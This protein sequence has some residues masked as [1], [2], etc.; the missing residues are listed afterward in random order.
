M[1]PLPS[2]SCLPVTV[3]AGPSDAAARLAT[4]RERDRRRAHAD[5]QA[6]YC[7]RLV[8][9]FFLC[10]LVAEPHSRNLSETRDKA[11]LRMKRLRETRE[12]S[13]EAKQE[14]AERRREVDADYRE[15][16]QK[17]KF[18]KKFGQGAFV[19]YYLPLHQVYGPH[20]VGKQFLWADEH[21]KR[22]TRSRTKRAS[23]AVSGEGPVE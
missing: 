10:E 19:N 15:R 2:N 22:H 1:S 17:K 18:I 8:S 12:L 4:S 13:E 21:P 3:P 9:L 14:A 16:R 11:R 23:L 6:R 20:I 7:E 5:A